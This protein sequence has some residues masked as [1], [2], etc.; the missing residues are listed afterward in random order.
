MKRFPSINRCSGPHSS[1]YGFIKYDGSSIRA[2]WSKKRGW[3]K[4]GSRWLLLDEHTPILAPAIQ[5]FK[6]KYGDDLPKVF[7]NSKLFRNSDR[8]I[9]YSEWFGAK[10][11]AGQHVEGD[12]KDI[13]LFDVNPIG[14]GF[15]SPRNFI[16]EFGHLDV[17]ECV[18]Q[19]D[20]TQEHIDDIRGDKMVY[21]SKYKIAS[22]FPE[23]LIC[24][25]GEGHKLWMSKIKYGSY[26]TELK[27]RFPVEWDKF[28]E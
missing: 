4:F 7:E 19:G 8:V 22:E 27:K 11:F 3:H 5:A 13:V 2:E 10:S 24:K 28:W 14:K 1:C 9:V 25:G 23:G 20:L 15:I 18:F 17:A 6:D 26:L 21:R 16:Y 12:P